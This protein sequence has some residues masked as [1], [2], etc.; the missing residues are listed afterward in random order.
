MENV[1]KKLIED[2]VKSQTVQQIATGFEECENMETL[3][4]RKEIYF[5]EFSI[6]DDSIAVLVKGSIFVSW[7]LNSRLRLSGDIV[8]AS[9]GFDLITYLWDEIPLTV[10]R[11]GSELGRIQLTRVKD[12]TVEAIFLE[13]V[14]EPDLDADKVTF[15]LLNTRDVVNKPVRPFNKMEVDWSLCELENDLYTIKIQQYSHYKEIMPILKSDGGFS[16]THYGEIVKRE[17]K[18]NRLESDEVINCLNSFLSFINGRKTGLVNVRKNYGDGSVW[19]DPLGY[20]NDPYKIV[21]SW[22]PSLSSVEPEFLNDLWTD[23]YRAWFVEDES[24][25]IRQLIQLY[26]ESNLNL[27]YIEN[28]LILSQT[29][30]EIFYDWKIPVKVHKGAASRIRAVL[31]DSLKISAEIPFVLNQLS[32]FKSI[33]FLDSKGA[34]YQKNDGPDCIVEIRN[35]IVHPERWRKDNLK[36][37]STSMRV[38]TWLLA[39]WYVELCILKAISYEGV[40]KNRLITDEERIQNVPWVGVV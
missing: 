2:L 9:A 14:S 18:M 38:N 1:E 34:V 37:I 22:F 5:G 24:E 29:A 16:V 15:S 3:G 40:Y 31:S 20:Q 39:N 35:S 21:R 19:T 32:E 27:I 25:N 8:S 6:I 12:S 28:C 26:V 10:I 30:L 11:D 36:K 17:G 7:S 33:S 13:L 4:S 23:F